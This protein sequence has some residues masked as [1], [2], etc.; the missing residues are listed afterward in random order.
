MTKRAAISS[1]TLVHRLA[2]RLATA[3]APSPLTRVSRRPLA[4]ADV[5]PGQDQDGE[6][7]VVASTTH[8]RELVPARVAG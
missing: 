2:M 4:V 1:P 3:K 5:A 6:R 8:C 7:Q